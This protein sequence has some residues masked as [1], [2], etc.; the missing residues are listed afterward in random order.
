MEDKLKRFIEDGYDI[1]L[2]RG[3]NYFLKRDNEER[4]VRINKELATMAIKKMGAT[5]VD[6][7][8]KNDI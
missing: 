5:E 3:N 8:L 7:G 6:K 1:V 2:I 4:L